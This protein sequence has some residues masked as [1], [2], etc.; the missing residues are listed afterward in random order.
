MARRP[1]FWLCP[2]CY[3]KKRGDP[4]TYICLRCTEDMGNVRNIYTLIVTRFPLL[5]KETMATVF[6]RMW[7]RFEKEYPVGKKV[8][9][10]E[11]E[12]ELSACSPNQGQCQGQAQ[13]ELCTN[14]F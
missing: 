2:C 3:E 8:K 11:A 13:E 6:R 14:P 12:P 5:D 9:K 1:F 4:G 10:A 7:Q